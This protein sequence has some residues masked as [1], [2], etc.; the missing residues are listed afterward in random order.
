MH[1]SGCYETFYN[2]AQPIHPSRFYALHFD[3]VM[4]STVAGGSEVNNPVGLFVDHEGYAGDL[5]AL[6]LG[7]RSQVKKIDRFGV[8]TTFAGTG[9]DDYLNGPRLSARFTRHTNPFVVDELGNIYVTENISNRIRKIGN[10][11]NV[12]LFA[13]SANGD[14]GYVNAQGGNARFKGC[15]SLAYDPTT[16]TIYVADGGNNRIRAIDLNGNVSTY[17]GTGTAGE[18]NGHVT[19]AT[20][21]N[22]IGLAIDLQRRFLYVSEFA[23]NS[24]YIRR[25]DLS[26]DMVTILCG[27]FIPGFQDGIGI[28]ARFNTISDIDVDEQGFI[29]VADAGNHAIRKVSPSGRVTTIAG[30]GTANY[31]DGSGTY[32]LFNDIADVACDHKGNIFVSDRLNNSVRRISWAIPVTVNAPALGKRLNN[33]E[34]VHYYTFTITEAM[35]Y[36]LEITRGILLSDF[37]VE[38]FG[39]DDDYNLIFSDFQATTVN[40]TVNFA[41]GEYRIRVSKNN[42]SADFGAYKLRIYDSRNLFGISPPANGNIAFDSDNDWYEFNVSSAGTYVVEAPYVSSSL[43]GNVHIYIYNQVGSSTAQQ[44]PDNLINEGVNSVS[45]NLAAGHYWIRVRAEEHDVFPND[46]K[47]LT[48]TYTIRVW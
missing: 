38:L 23:A 21:T 19:I 29:Y 48:G 2:S 15:S 13:G 20:F 39:P 6:Y 47:F 10:D 4:V 31:K 9:E 5:G 7:T 3:S 33:L 26:T 28:N 37:N 44:I 1:G 40:H 36:T 43:N 17:A 34:D 18:G 32:A 14:E 30:N 35:N 12:Y 41:P 22:P 27:S 46:W 8:L 45:G 42:C 11:D 16:Q 24:H 25:I